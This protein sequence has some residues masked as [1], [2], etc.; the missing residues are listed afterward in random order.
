MQLTESQSNMMGAFDRWHNSRQGILD[1]LKMFMGAG[2][3]II[4]KSI[5]VIKFKRY[6]SI[7]K[8]DS[9]VGV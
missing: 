6:K 5:Q 7:S 8:N 4:V 1:K 9:R 2:R 3:K